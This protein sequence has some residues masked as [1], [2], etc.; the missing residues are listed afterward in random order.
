MLDNPAALG[1]IN[2]T[3]QQFLKV[4]HSVTIDLVKS[5]LHLACSLLKHFNTHRQFQ[6]LSSG[7][8]PSVGAWPRVSPTCWCGCCGLVGQM[9]LNKL[10]LSCLPPTFQFYYS[11][12]TW[13]KNPPTPIS[14]IKVHSND[15][16]CVRRHAEYW[17]WY[18]PRVALASSLHH[19]DS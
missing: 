9:Q 19:H 12:G 1:W 18:C 4:L 7:P 3:L 5:P 11:A 10:A 6:T 16:D 17:W 15:V 13:T 14:I 8:R 2:V